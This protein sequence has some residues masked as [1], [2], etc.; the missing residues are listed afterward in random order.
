MDKQE[1]R[2]HSYGHA[3]KNKFDHAL[4]GMPLGGEDVATI[5]PKDITCKSC[6]LVIE[7]S[8]KEYIKQ[9][10]YPEN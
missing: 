3:V 5:Y 8:L 1:V 7:Q 4:C 9:R 10:C 2:V 6:L